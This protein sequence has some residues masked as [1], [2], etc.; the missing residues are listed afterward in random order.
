MLKVVDLRQ[1]DRKD[2]HEASQRPGDDSQ[3]EE[4]EERNFAGYLAT[5]KKRRWH[6]LGPQAMDTA[7]AS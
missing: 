3:Q 1:I 2:Q 6:R 5:A 7:Q 4:N